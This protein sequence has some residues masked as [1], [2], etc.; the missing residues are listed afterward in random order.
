MHSISN[1]RLY[2]FDNARGIASILGAFYHVALIFSFPWL[3]NIDPEYFLEETTFFIQ[4]LNVAR[5]PLFLF[6]SGFFA[7]Y[8]L[9][10]YKKRIFVK[11]RFRRLFIPLL[12][13][14]LVILPLQF[15]ILNGHINLKEFFGLIYPAKFTWSLSH[16]WFLY[17]VFVFSLLLIVLFYLPPGIKSMI[18]KALRFFNRNVFFIILFWSG[19]MFLGYKTGKEM[20]ALIVS[21]NDL[22]HFRTM[23]INLPVFLFGAYTFYFLDYVSERAISGRKKEIIVSTLF[24][25]AFVVIF[26][27]FPALND[28]GWFLYSVMTFSLTLLWLNLIYR[29]LNYTNRYLGFISDASYAFYILHHPVIIFL[30]VLYVKLQR[31]SWLLLDYF[32]LCFLSVALTYLLYYI[33]VYKSR[34]GSFLVTGYLNEEDRKLPGRLKL[35]I[36]K[37]LRKRPI[38]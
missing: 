19:L 7:M 16:L 36:Y 12:F 2:Y 15:L 18:D 1:G 32:I 20:E 33:L 30:G 21:A 4:Y 10:K 26:H 9:N 24:Y 34:L 25:V 17:H 29:F 14:V 5:M 35:K 13:G 22:F 3:V 11:R 27:L 8:S 6:I 28:L 23:G 37:R 38:L 31:T